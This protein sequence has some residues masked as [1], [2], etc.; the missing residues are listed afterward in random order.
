MDR[1]LRPDRFD[2]EPSAPGATKKWLHW[3]RTF[4]NFTDSLTPDQKN[5]KLNLLSNFV[6]PVVF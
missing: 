1:L 3:Y 2:T 6:S 5:N 4:L